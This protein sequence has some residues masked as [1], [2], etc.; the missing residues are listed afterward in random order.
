[1][2]WAFSDIAENVQRPTSNVQCRIEKRSCEKPL[3]REERLRFA[4]A[5]DAMF[6]AFVPAQNFDFDAQKINR[7]SHFRFLETRHAHRI[8]LGRYDHLQISPEAA[9]DESV[10]FL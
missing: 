5:R 4:N 10:Q 3:G 2:S 7:H 9:I 6:P 8:L 1:M